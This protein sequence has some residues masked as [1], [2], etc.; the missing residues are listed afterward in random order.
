MAKRYIRINWQQSPSTATPRNATNLNIMDKGIDDLDNAV[1]DLYSVKA[2][3]ADIV[4]VQTNNTAKICGAA[5]AYSMGQSIQ[6]LNNYL[7]TCLSDKDAVDNPKYIATQ[8]I[9]RYAASASDKPS[10]AGGVVIALYLDSTPGNQI[11]IRLAIDRTGRIF[12]SVYI[13]GVTFGTWVEK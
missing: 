6:A 11:V 4:N 13:A 9:F 12:T 5:M 7:V 3:K 2:A 1:E 10:D 8:G